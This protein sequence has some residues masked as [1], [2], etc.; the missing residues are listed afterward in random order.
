MAPPS[1]TGTSAPPGGRKETAQELADR[2]LRSRRKR[3]AAELARRALELDAECTDAQVVLAREEAAGPRDL[4]SRLK[5]IVDRAEA[6]LGVPFLHEHRGLLWHLEEA[7]PY[8]RACLALAAAHEKAGRPG[9]AIPHLQNLLASDLEDH[10][11]AR[12]R[13]VC[14]LL[15]ANDLKPLAALLKHWDDGRSAFMAWAVLL[16]RIRSGAEKEARQ[17][18]LRART[19]NPYVEDFLTGRRKQPRQVPGACEAGSPEEAAAALKLFGETW[20]NDR[21]GMYWLFRNS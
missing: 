15:A 9:Q 2:A 21:E 1:R 17:A 11:G 12:F 13:L 6:R 16:E 8:L 10:L 19:I 14:C 18:L 3:E 4:A 7:R 5:I 20:A